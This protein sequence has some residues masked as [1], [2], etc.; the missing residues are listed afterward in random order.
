MDERKKKKKDGKRGGR[1]TG[2]ILTWYVADLQPKSIESGRESSTS[3]HVPLASVRRRNYGGNRI[4]RNDNA[5]ENTKLL[6]VSPFSHSSIST[7][8]L[9]SF[10]SLFSSLLAPS[11]AESPLQYHLAT[12][13]SVL[14]YLFAFAGKSVKYRDLYP[15]WG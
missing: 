11:P 7:S 6:S 1:L 12:P 13:A 8:A 10:P 3:R 2:T 14:F 15:V 4:N 9:S 5:K